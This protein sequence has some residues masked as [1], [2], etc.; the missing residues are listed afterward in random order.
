MIVRDF[1]AATARRFDVIVVGGGIYGA[2][3]LYEATRRGLSACLCEAQDFGSGTSWN[4]LR[5]LHGGLRYLQ[6]GELGRFHESVAARREF[7]I[8]FQDL[9][10]PMRFMM[11][12][13]RQG[14]RR[15]SVLRAALIANDLLSARRNHGV[16]DALHIG[17][18][19]LLDA[20][21]VRG[22]CPVV[23]EPGL[24]GA[25]CWTDYVM[26]SSERILMELL[27]NAALDGAIA[28]NYARVVDVKSASG[29]FRGVCVRDECTGS[30]HELAASTIVNCTGAE[31]AA[32]AE[33]LGGAPPKLF[34]PS[35]AFNVLLEHELPGGAALAVSGPSAGS[36]LLFLVPMGRVTM[37]GTCHV[38][39]PGGTVVAEAT[40][41]EIAAF[42]RSL[43]DA[44]PQWGVR[45][46][47]VMRV[48]AGLLPV[49]TPGTTRL[50]RGEAIVD[51]GRSGG[52]RG[53]YSVAGVKFTTALRAARRIASKLAP[54]PAVS[55]RESDSIRVAAQTPWLIDHTR[56][57]SADP[58]ATARALATVMREEAAHDMA[59]LI[60]RR[61]NWST[62]TRAEFV[63]ARV[64]ELLRPRSEA[65]SEPG[66][67]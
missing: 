4:S 50:L 26:L 65:L 31:V 67:R 36:Q 43:N 47:H 11:P 27:R 57:W 38:P 40:E 41:P 66:V 21:S 6:T 17:R 7:A 60:L 28:L 51:H 3:V 30:L 22:A 45:R 37:A 8:L 46:E 15:G 52:L 12:L 25:A 42:L 23:R 55:S 62:A 9:V 63:R 53:A 64:S 34:E 35:L 5:I 13:Y 33:R 56:L 18:G 24:Q 19:G 29:Q 10:Q 54:Q 48:L 1:A 61:T 49:R 58:N 2:A 16:I 20:G 59:D 39:R 44:V 14:L 32:L